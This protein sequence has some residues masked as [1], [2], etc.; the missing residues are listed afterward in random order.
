MTHCFQGLCGSVCACQCVACRPALQMTG[1]H[2]YP[3]PP[4]PKPQ[5][6]TFT[7]GTLEPDPE[8]LAAAARGEVLQPLTPSKERTIRDDERQRAY[9]DL[10]R[11]LATCDYEADAVGQAISKEVRYLTRMIETR[12]FEKYLPK[13]DGGS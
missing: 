5:L 12:E 10:A 11:W 13:P 2:V 4:M 9:A 7:V 6:L 3:Q 8:L 1:I